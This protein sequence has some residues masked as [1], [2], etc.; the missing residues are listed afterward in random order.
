MNNNHFKYLLT[1]IACLALIISSC[2][3]DDDLVESNE[4]PSK[5]E[6]M[7]TK[8]SG[9]YNVYDTLFNYLYEME[10]VHERSIDS[11]GFPWDT[12]LFNNQFNLRGY[13]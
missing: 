6:V 7:F 8:V 4:G 2:K 11:N 13:Y 5:W 10:I 9:N 3:K 1:I 12:L